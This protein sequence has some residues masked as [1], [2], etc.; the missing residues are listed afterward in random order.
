[1]SVYST[2]YA[3]T[4]RSVLVRHRE[5]VCSEF[6]TLTRKLA[7]PS[8]RTHSPHPSNPAFPTG[9]GLHGRL[10]TG[11]FRFFSVAVLDVVAAP[12]IEL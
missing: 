11:K 1:M 2:V 9:D 7:P 5:T 10:G 4:D 8:E 6:G 3:R 12:F